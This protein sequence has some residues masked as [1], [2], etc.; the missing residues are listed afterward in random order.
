ML[1]RFEWIRSSG[2]FEDFRW[3]ETTPD[4]ARINVFLGANGSGKSSL[5]HALG[6]A[7]HNELQQ[8]N[9]SL[10]IDQDQ[11]V[12]STNG[13]QDSFFERIHVFN[14]DFV[15]RAHRFSD[16]T[17]S[18]QGVLTI[19]ERTVEDDERLAALKAMVPDLV[20]KRDAHHATME[21]AQG[22][23]QK[24]LESVSKNVVNDLTKLGGKY[25][26][27]SNY[28]KAK[29]EKNFKM[30]RTGWNVLSTKDL[31][32]DK[33][34]VLSS[35]PRSISWKA[36]KISLAQALAGEALECLEATPTTLILNTLKSHPEAS[37]WVREGRLLHQ[38]L[39]TCLFCAGEL[40]PERKSKIDEHFSN[41]V[42]RLEARIGVLLEELDTVRAASQA[43]IDSI[44][45]KANAYSDLQSAFEIA[46]KKYQLE[47]TALIQSVDNARE[48]L[49]KK[50]QNVLEPV[51]EWAA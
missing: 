24:A 16:D 4:F 44:P 27:R 28:S 10:V 29:V 48:K 13:H 23:Y 18:M 50:L 12:R 43:A 22:S 5:S 6:R 32:A 36:P 20:D 15:R 17:P 3:E 34:L 40:E 51:A 7:H 38:D 39:G 21:S 30:P 46:A 42:A 35:A 47:A 11:K 26:S 1:R 41:E 49:Q 2:I 14:T 31:Q 25:Q 33:E 45:D 9:L 8:V 19:G 37:A